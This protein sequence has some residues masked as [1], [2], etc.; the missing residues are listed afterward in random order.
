MGGLWEQMPFMGSMGIIFAMASLGLPG[1]GNFVA[2]FL[3]LAGAF[4]AN[5][6]VTVVASIGLVFATMYSLRILQKV[7]YG[8]KNSASPLRDLSLREGLV[9]AIMT[10]AIFITGLFPHPVTSTAAPA[11]RKIIITREKASATHVQNPIT[12]TNFS[13]NQ[14]LALPILPAL[15]LSC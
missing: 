1:L 6:P 13:H 14:P 12:V 2:E 9:L 5:V 10:I 15:Y 11:I 8:E 3:T 7:F 4:R